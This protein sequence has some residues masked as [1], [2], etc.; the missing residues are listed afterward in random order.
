M[1]FSQWFEDPTIA[2][3]LKNNITL[4][5]LDDLIFKVEVQILYGLY[6]PYEPLFHNTTIV[7]IV[8]PSRYYYYN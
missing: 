7:R 3:N 5:A 4:Y 2:K 8:E 1:K 6:A